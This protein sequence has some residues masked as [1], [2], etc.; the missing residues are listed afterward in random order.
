MGCRILPVVLLVAVPLAGQEVDEATLEARM[1]AFEEAFA[2]LARNWESLTARRANLWWETGYFEALE[3]EK[4]VI[5][6]VS[7]LD[8]AEKVRRGEVLTA[9]PVWKEKRLPPVYAFPLSRDVAF[10]T[11]SGQRFM[12][13]GLLRRDQLVALGQDPQTGA[14]VMVVVLEEPTLQHLGEQYG[15][16]LREFALRE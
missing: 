9:R 12:R 11:S 4:I 5:F 10:F 15:R 7:G 6:Q 2:P 14:V 1:A 8:L 13:E 3:G 16:K